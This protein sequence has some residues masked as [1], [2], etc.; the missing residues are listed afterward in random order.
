M[1][2]PDNVFENPYKADQFLQF[3][4]NVNEIIP[5]LVSTLEAYQAFTIS[6]N[7]EY[8]QYLLIEKGIHI[9]DKALAEF[10]SIHDVL[11]CLFGQYGDLDV[12]D[13]WNSYVKDFNEHVAHAECKS[14]GFTIFKA[15]CFR[16]HKLEAV[17]EQWSDA[18]DI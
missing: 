9:E 2:L 4:M 13:V 18:E 10:F 6:E 12:E 17:Q 15:Y 7:L 1:N 5:N 11:A 16:A 14:A 3:S 8:A